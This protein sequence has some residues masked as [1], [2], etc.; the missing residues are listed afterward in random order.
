M[1][2]DTH[3]RHVLSCHK[4]VTLSL[5]AV[6]KSFH[7]HSTTVLRL[8]VLGAQV[9]CIIIKYFELNQGF[10]RGGQVTVFLT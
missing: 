1:I 6:V 9:L 3:V 10:L 5:S 7:K 4:R 2:Y 8:V